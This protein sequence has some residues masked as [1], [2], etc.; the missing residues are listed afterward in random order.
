MKAEIK[1]MELWKDVFI[2]ILW[3]ADT[4]KKLDMQEIHKDWEDGGEGRIEWSKHWVK[5][6]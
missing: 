5:C 1:F 2:G 3:E 4:E 6:W